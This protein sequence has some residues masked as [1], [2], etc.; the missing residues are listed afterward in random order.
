M[1]FYDE[2]AKDGKPFRLRLCLQLQS[3]LLFDLHKHNKTPDDKVRRDGQ[4]AFQLWRSA[5]LDHPY[6]Y[7]LSR[8]LRC[9]LPSF[10]PLPIFYPLSSSVGKTNDPAR[11]ME[12]ASQLLKEAE[13]WGAFKSVGTGKDRRFLWNNAIVARHFAKPKDVEAWIEKK[14]TAGQKKAKLA[15]RKEMKE[16]DEAKAK[17]DNLEGRG[18][19]GDVNMDE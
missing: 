18:Q 19:D 4:L 14:K 16:R 6:E 15:R 2:R 9:T 7:G 3:H 8:L 10:L 17:G 12:K 11:Y 1:E 5:G 13:K